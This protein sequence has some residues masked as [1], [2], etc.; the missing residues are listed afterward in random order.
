MSTISSFASGDGDVLLL[1]ELLPFLSPFVLLIVAF[2]L[3]ARLTRALSEGVPSTARALL[4]AADGA[5]FAASCAYVTGRLVG[6]GFD[7]TTPREW[8]A[9]SGFAG[10]DV[11]ERTTFPMSAHCAPGGAELVPAWVNPVLITGTLAAVVALAVGLAAHLR[12]RA[13]HRAP[14]DEPADRR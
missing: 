13:G 8:C 4:L 11:V 6:P 2:V 9:L 1:V 3:T 10:A 12:L 14:T 7:W 5:A